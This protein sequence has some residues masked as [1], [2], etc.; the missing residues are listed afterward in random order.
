MI[1]HE[2]KSSFFDK[3]NEG[4]QEKYIIF[5]KQLIDDIE[6][7]YLISEGNYNMNT[8][9]YMIKKQIRC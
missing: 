2:F 1:Y 7:P 5:I 6:H 8:A 3:K 4:H 9:E